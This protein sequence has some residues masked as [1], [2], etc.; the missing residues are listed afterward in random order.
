MV[1]ANTVKIGC[2]LMKYTNLNGEDNQLL[3]CNYGP[4]GNWDG[5]PIYEVK[6]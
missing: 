3:V 5:E 6:N 2:G 4:S 1:W